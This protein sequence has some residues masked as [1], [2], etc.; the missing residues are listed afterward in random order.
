[1]HDPDF[2]A[3]LSAA[4]AKLAADIG[5][6]AP[7]YTDEEEQEQLRCIAGQ[8][9]LSRAELIDIVLRRIQHVDPLSPRDVQRKRLQLARSGEDFLREVSSQPDRHFCYY[10][11]SSKR[12]AEHWRIRKNVYVDVLNLSVILILI[13]ALVVVSWALASVLNP[14]FP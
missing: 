14:R 11:L 1:M 8:A 3:E 4:S 7:H 5:A 2:R 10:Y 9:G 12:R 6:N 13:A